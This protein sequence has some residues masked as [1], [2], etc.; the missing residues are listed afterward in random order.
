MNFLR[1]LTVS[2]SAIFL[3]CFNTVIC[4]AD[5]LVW[6]QNKEEVFKLAKEQDKYIYLF[7]GK[8]G[9]SICQN[10]LKN[11]NSNQTLRPILDDNYIIWYSLRTNPAHVAEV[12]VYTEEFDKVAQYMPFLYVID[13][14]D[15]DKSLTSKWG[16][17]SISSLENMLS[18]DLIPK[19]GLKWYEDKEEVME[20]AKEQNKLIFMLVG[21]GTSNNSKKVMAH[22]N[23][24]PVRQILEENFIL[25]YSQYEDPDIEIPTETYAGTFEEASQTPPYLYIIDPTEPDKS[26]SYATGYQDADQ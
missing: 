21:R 12:K 17:Q 2:I 24:E 10:T 5:D 26:I 23:E 13:P 14:E 22:L 1:Q 20:L 11:L 16:S 3:L 9:C 6:L 15:P 8:T 25:W 7:V 4:S 19:D 18:F